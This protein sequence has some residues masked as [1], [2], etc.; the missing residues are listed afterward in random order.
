MHWITRHR[1]PM[2]RKLVPRQQYSFVDFAVVFCLYYSMTGLAYDGFRVVFERILWRN[3]LA[4]HSYN[5]QVIRY[6]YYNRD[7][8]DVL[9]IFHDS[10]IL[11]HFLVRVLESCHDLFH[12]H[13]AL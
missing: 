3:G 11:F 1:L 6:Y 7:S 2:C 9:M 10:R 4:G 5:T 12:V 13:R 8:L